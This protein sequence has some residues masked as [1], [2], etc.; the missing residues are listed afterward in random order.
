M[1]FQRTQPP[2]AQHSS[3][4]GSHSTVHYLNLRQVQP[5][6]TLTHDRDPRHVTVCSK[7]RAMTSE[8][9]T[10]RQRRQ[11]RKEQKLTKRCAFFS[12]LFLHSTT[13]TRRHGSRKRERCHE[14]VRMIAD[15]STTLL[16]ANCLKVTAVSAQLL[17]CT[18]VSQSM[19][20]YQTMGLLG[21]VTTRSF[22]R[23]WVRKFRRHVQTVEHAACPYEQL[24]AS[25]WRAHPAGVPSTGFTRQLDPSCCTLS[26]PAL[27][28]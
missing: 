7:S 4:T 6:R 27:L 3:S 23:N 11:K 8:L 10:R 2:K 13:S 1:Q 21:C 26:P 19:F 24:L 28:S 18:A 22:A 14:R 15:C 17:P 12:V 9:E 16:K 25:T 5:S 20:Q